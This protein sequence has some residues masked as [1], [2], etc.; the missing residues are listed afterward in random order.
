MNKITR[1][2]WSKQTKKEREIETHSKNYET[3]YIYMNLY[4]YYRNIKHMK[5]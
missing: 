3:I 5:N 1:V 2:N 4:I